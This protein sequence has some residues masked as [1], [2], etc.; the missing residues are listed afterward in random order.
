MIKVLYDYDEA[1]R[2]ITI[3]EIIIKNI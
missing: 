3:R 2:D 1:F